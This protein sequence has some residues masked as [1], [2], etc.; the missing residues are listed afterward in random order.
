MKV[1]NLI[2]FK[3]SYGFIES[4]LLWYNLFVNTL[5]AQEFVANPYFR[6]IG[7]STVD[8]KQW[9]IPWYGDDNKVSHI[10]KHVNTSIIESIAEH[11]GEL[12][13]FRGGN[14]KLMVIDLEFLGDV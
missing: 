11:F 4:A 5:K 14:Y 3:Y 8:V 9:R 10:N 12:T 7:N 6:C 13:V 1:L 2:L